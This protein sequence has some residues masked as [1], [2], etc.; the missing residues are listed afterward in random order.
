MQP[1]ADEYRNCALKNGVDI[2][3]LY[4]D[5]DGFCNGVADVVER[6]QPHNGYTTCMRHNLR[7][8]KILYDENGRLTAAK[9]RFDVPYPNDLKANIVQR[10]WQLFRSAMPAY[11]L[12]IRKAA[13]RRGLISIN[14]RTAEF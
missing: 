1:P 5:L 10:N 14:H 9:Q 7:T 3:I 6:Y 12:Q 13:E 2:D 11:E 4:R 8:C